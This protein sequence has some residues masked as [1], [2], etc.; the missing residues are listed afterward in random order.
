VLKTVEDM[1]GLRA[2]TIYDRGA[3]ALHDVVVDKLADA[4]TSQYTAVQPPTP[5]LRNP[6]LSEADERTAQLE[7]LSLKA[8]FWNLDLGNPVLEH[9]VLYAGLRG[10]PLPS[11]DLAL[12][13]P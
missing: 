10:T 13:G 7:K 3:H 5:F 2:L 11:A 9:D 12:I 8:N 6:L 1:F 4:N